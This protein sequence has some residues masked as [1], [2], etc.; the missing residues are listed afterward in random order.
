VMQLTSVPKLGLEHAAYRIETE[1]SAVWIDCPSAF[2]RTLE[3]VRNILFTHPHFMGASNQY[4]QLWQAE[5]WLHALDADQPL[6]RSFPID[7]RFTDDFVIDGIESYHIG[8]HTPGYT[9][10]IYQDMLF[11]CDYAFPP[12][13]NMRLNPFGPK[14][15]TLQGA[16]R[17]RA[18]TE[19]KPL[20]TV[21][22]YNYVCDFS[23][24][25]DNFDQAI[26]SQP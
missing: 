18:L 24:W 3:P 10:Y 11:I 19:K 5:V 16:L 8:G 25:F 12:G 9:I 20:T 13:P 4:R 14:H 22:G 21:C 2:N 17:I 7:H 15:E 23:D 6:I 26:R 1:K